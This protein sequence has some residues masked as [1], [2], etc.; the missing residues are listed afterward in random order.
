MMILLPLDMQ[1]CLFRV[2]LIYREGVLVV[3]GSDVFL[4][5]S[6]L[7]LR[8]AHKAF[9]WARAEGTSKVHLPQDL[10]LKLSI[11]GTCVQVILI[12]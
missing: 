3:V 5:S 2:L 11:G 8:H 10:P 4:K 7:L 1:R 6:E 9:H 12:N